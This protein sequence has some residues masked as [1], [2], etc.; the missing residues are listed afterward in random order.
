MYFIVHLRIAYLR[1]RM[2]PC[3]ACG[4][5]IPEDFVRFNSLCNKKGFMKSSNR[6]IEAAIVTHR[7]ECHVRM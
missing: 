3:H 2:S 5:G 7:H 6:D 4:A 1:T